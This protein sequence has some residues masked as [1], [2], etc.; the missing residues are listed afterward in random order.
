ME[1]YLSGERESEIK[2][3]YFNGEIFAMA[4]AGREHNQ[5]SSNIVRILGNQTKLTSECSFHLTAMPCKF[6]IYNLCNNA[7]LLHPCLK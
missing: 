2:S 5:I 6:K 3:E 1:E 4:G 7:V